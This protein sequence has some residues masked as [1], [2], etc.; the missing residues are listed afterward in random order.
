[1]LGISVQTLQKVQALL[2]PFGPRFLLSVSSLT[3]PCTVKAGNT[4]E[5]E[6]TQPSLSNLV[7]HA[8]KVHSNM[9]APSNAPGVTHKI[10][11]A[12]AKI[13]GDF[14]K[15]GIL[16]PELTHTQAGFYKVFSAWILEDDLA[17][18]MGET[19]RIHCLLAYMESCFLLPSD[20][21][22]RN[23]LTKIYTKL[24]HDIKEELKVF[25]IRT[26][27]RPIPTHGQQN[28]KSKITLSTDTWTT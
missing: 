15:A 18:S 22:V 21:T 10:S 19:V 6:P 4:F 25:T 20:T 23:T 27:Y 5:D 11:A 12:S 1:M 2:V 24:Y 7:T 26:Y 13:M 9:D 16:N 28:V 8:R 3:F 14:L 17:F